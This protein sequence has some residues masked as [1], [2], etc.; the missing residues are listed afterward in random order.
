MMEAEHSADPFAI[1]LCAR[2]HAQ[3]DADQSHA[4][5]YREVPSAKLKTAPAK[6]VAMVATVAHPRG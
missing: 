3:P 4:A 1:D 5:I 2:N 6:P